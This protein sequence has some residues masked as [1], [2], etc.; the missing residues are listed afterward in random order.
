MQLLWDSN[1]ELLA[2]HHSSLKW[3]LYRFFGLSAQ[4]YWKEKNKHF[5]TDNRIRNFSYLKNDKV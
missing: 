2:N 5:P 3:S 1:G 4:V